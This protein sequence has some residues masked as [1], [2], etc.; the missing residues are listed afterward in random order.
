MQVPFKK[1]LCKA[2]QDTTAVSIVKNKFVS[3]KGLNFI[4]LF[5]KQRKPKGAHIVAARG[6]FAPLL[7]RQLRHCQ[8]TAK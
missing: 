7:P 2:L 3:T 5:S 1:P 4:K 6:A 8:E